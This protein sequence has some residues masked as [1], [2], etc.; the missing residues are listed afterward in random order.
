MGRSIGAAHDPSSADYRATFPRCAQGGSLLAGPD[1]R[2][3]R[4]PAQ[5]TQASG[6]RAG[7]AAPEPRAGTQTTRLSIEGGDLGAI[8]LAKRRAGSP[9]SGRCRPA[10]DPVERHGDH[11]GHRRARDRADARRRLVV[12]RRQ[13][14]GPLSPGLGI[15][16]PGGAGRVVDS[17]PGRDVPGRHRL[18]RRARS[19]SVAA[20]RGRHEAARHPGR[21]ARLEMALHLPRA[22]HRQREPSRRARRHA[23]TLR[24]HIGRGHEQLLRAAARQPDLR[25]VRHG[26]A[27]L[28]AGR[29]SWQVSRP[30]RPVQRGGLLRHAFRGRGGAGRAVRCLA[31]QHAR[32]RRKA[33]RRKLRKARPARPRRQAA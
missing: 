6:H 20:A 4:R 14:Q 29:Q 27:A 9:R 30:Q 18:G 2:G 8:S 16:R 25:H 12:P 15:F 7:Y 13:H 5:E 17:R 32:H 19:R 26:D 22:R 11:A 10:A 3:G 31:R 33:R 28:P 23:A 1:R 21:V 24:H